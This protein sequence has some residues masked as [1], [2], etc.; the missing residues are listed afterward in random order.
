MRMDSRHAELAPCARKQAPI[1]KFVPRVQGHGEDRRHH[2][3]GPGR[4][5]VRGR[6]ASYL[7]SWLA[8]S[9]D[10]HVNDA[11]AEDLVVTQTRHLSRSWSSADLADKVA[12]Y[13]Q[14]GVYAP[15]IGR[16]L[17]HPFATNL[18]NGADGEAPACHPYTRSPSPHRATMDVAECAD[19]GCAGAMCTEGHDGCARAVVL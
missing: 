11:E 2:A 12:R 8:Y 14:K 5:Q 6:G 15:A 19:A 17:D 13:L 16:D 10:H 1:V 9:R 18:L 4:G 3:K 7:P